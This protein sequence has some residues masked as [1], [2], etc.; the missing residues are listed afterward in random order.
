MTADRVSGGHQIGVPV[1]VIWGT[2]DRLLLPRQAE[3]AAAEVPGTGLI[4]V[5]GG[6]HFA[7]RDAPDAVI[8][9]LLRP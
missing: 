2:R 4:W 3:W 6:G 8:G 5:E 7:H 1:A 9:A